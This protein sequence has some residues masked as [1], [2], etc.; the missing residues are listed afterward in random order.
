M[1]FTDNF[2]WWV[3]KEPEKMVGED[4]NDSDD[5]SIVIP[6]GMNLSQESPLEI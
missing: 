4:A 6:N 2:E 3:D 5:D 1:V